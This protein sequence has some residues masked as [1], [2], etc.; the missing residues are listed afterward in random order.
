MV[1]VVRT[2]IRYVVQYMFTTQAILLCN[3][4]QPL[5]AE[6]A[7]RIDVK[8]LTLPTTVRKWQ[9]ASNAQGVAQLRLSCSELT[10]D[11]GD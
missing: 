4:E 1:G 2:S 8:S 11:L 9:L 5:R 10:K 6:C 3:G 7:L